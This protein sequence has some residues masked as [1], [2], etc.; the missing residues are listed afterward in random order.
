MNDWN[1][2]NDVSTSINNLNLNDKYNQHSEN[3]SNSDKEKPV[4]NIS[5]KN[6]ASVSAENANSTVHEPVVVQEKVCFS[7]I[8]QFFILFKTFK[9]KITIF[10]IA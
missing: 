9:S 6:W 8:T 4:E 3:L 5:V 7:I 10:L 1:Q 2:V